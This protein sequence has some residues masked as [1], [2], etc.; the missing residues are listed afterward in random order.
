NGKAS[1]ITI[2]TLNYTAYADSVSISIPFVLKMANE[3]SINGDFI[4][5]AKQADNF[6]SGAEKFY[7][8]LPAS[9]NNEKTSTDTKP[10]GFWQLFF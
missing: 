3:S 10:E 2:D 7:V 4:W 8:N 9:V 1:T 6:P 5:L